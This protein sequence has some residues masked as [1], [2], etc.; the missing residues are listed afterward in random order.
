MNHRRIYAFL[1]TA[2]AMVSV[3]L[4]AVAADHDKAGLVVLN[5]STASKSA[6]RAFFLD[7][8]PD[9]AIPEAELTESDAVEY[10]DAIESAATMSSDRF[11]ASRGSTITIVAI[12]DLSGAVPT[13]KVDEKDRVSRI[14]ADLHTAIAVVKKVVKRDGTERKKYGSVTRTYTLTK[15]RSTLVVS[16]KQSA[17][18]AKAPAGATP[19]ETR[20]AEDVEE[21]KAADPIEASKTI[22]TG[23][24]EHLFLAA[25]VPVTKVDELKV[26]D[27]GGAIDVK[28]KPSSFYA[29]VNYSLGDL[30]AQKQPWEGLS[31]KGFVSVSKQPLDSYGVGLG[32]R[33]PDF[34]VLGWDFS[35]LSPFVGYFV[36]TTEV[37]D[38]A[39]VKTEK[40]IRGWRAGI[41][42]NLDK[43]LGWLGDGGS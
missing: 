6:N 4:G 13:F 41:S 1:I 8:L 22:I 15:H 31:L 42:F 32:Y 17:G 37:T 39:G 19:E 35:A 11:I 3:S 5:L 21:A 2:I 20:E 10:L 24:A 28:K 38:D 14:V 25:D 23:P 40:E 29:S 27:S 30:Y 12:Y 9:N 43:A 36:T 16:A 7:S 18:A 33:T 34:S 26:P